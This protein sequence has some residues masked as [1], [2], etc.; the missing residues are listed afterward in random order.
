MTYGIEIHIDMEEVDGKLEIVKVKSK[1][2][3][4][5]FWHEISIEKVKNLICMKE[6]DK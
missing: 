4:L 1:H 2:R 5:M 6:I 3:G